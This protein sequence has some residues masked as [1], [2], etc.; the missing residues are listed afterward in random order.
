MDG[1]LLKPS[2]LG[3]PP[4]GAAPP[5]LI[6]ELCHRPCPSHEGAMRKKTQGNAL[7]LADG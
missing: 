6:S 7:G 2:P 1:K 5:G 3:W 4:I